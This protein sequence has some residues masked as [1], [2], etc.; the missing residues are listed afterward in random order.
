M[1]TT[2]RRTRD[3][4]PPDL[5]AVY[6]KL[7]DQIGNPAAVDTPQLGRVEFQS[8]AGIANALNLLRLETARAAG[9]PTTGVF[10]AGYN[11]GLGPSRGGC[12]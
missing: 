5:D 2:R 7:I 11:R 4:A 9:I 8:S 10:V 1:P 12:L 3:A 6:S